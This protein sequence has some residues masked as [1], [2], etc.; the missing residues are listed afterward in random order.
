LR[1]PRIVSEWDALLVGAVSDKL[2]NVGIGKHL[3]LLSFLGPWRTSR[4]GAI[5]GRFL[6]LCFRRFRPLVRQTQW[7]YQ[8]RSP[9]RLPGGRAAG[10]G[11]HSGR[12]PQPLPRHQIQKGNLQALGISATHYPSACPSTTL[13]RASRRRPTPFLSARALRY[14]D[15]RPRRAM[16]LNNATTGNSQALYLVGGG[17][18]QPLTQ[19]QLTPSGLASLGHRPALEA[20][21]LWTDGDIAHEAQ[22]EVRGRVHRPAASASG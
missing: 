7:V 14:R 9:G 5:V 1:K 2:A 21:L 19:S 13:A 4:A 10:F 16:R 18:P 17:L 15:R 6:G 8:R 3:F 12:R 22:G 20:L 11:R